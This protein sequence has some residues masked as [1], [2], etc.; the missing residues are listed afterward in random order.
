[1]SEPSLKKNFILSTVYHILLVIMPFITAPYVSRVL[2]ADGIGIYSFTYSVQ[3]Y[4]SMF[5]ALGTVSYGSREIA[6]NRHV[7]EE[8]SLLFWEIELLTVITTSLCIALWCAFIAIT[9][10]YRVYYLILTL[11]LVATM[12]DI[13]WFYTGME[14][15]K[16]TVVPNGIFKIIGV[17]SIFIFVKT[18]E[19]I[20]AYI[21]IMAL[22]AL[23]G[24]ITMWCYLP[25]FIGRVRWRSLKVKRHC[26]ETLIYFIPT[27]ATSVYTVLDKTLIG[28]ITTDTSENGYYEQATKITNMA[29]SLTFASL[30][31]LLGSRIS[32]LFAENKIEE[33]KGRINFSIDY[34]LFTG[35]G[36]WLGIVGVAPRFVPL[37]FGG[38]YE[39]VIS[40]LYYLSPIVLII[41]V[42]NCL[43]AQYY[44]PAG[45]RALSAKFII[46]GSI[47]NL[48][49]NLILIPRF[50]SY[51]AII[52]SIVAEMIITFQYMYFCNGFLHY[53]T[54]ILQGWKKLVSGIAMLC[55]VRWVDELISI[56]VVAVWVEIAVGV[57]TYCATLLLLKDSFVVKVGKAVMSRFKKI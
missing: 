34:I 55:I 56:N 9:N 23:L 10:M 19:D 33:I 47:I 32:L 25:R 26:R 36:I 28:L 54:I 44:N 39:P 14:E 3:M 35:V 51:G 24:N 48:I 21:L 12:F 13:S 5:A 2:T 29:K 57:I 4:F 6:R 27:I 52:A 46:V 1:M 22:V 50:K 16:Y 38:G 43:G 20:N 18:K 17:V 30:N 8:R 42:S 49:L 31:T 11:N 45:L 41:G 53:K 40:L 37:F 7:K 15:F